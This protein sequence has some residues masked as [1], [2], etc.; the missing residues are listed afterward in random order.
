MGKSK[1]NAIGI[2]TVLLTSLIFLNACQ[3]AAP[4]VVP[5]TDSTATADT[6]DTTGSTAELAAPGQYHESP[7][8]SERV[9]RGELPPVGERLPVEPLVI[10]PVQQIGQYG[11][12]LLVGDIRATDP[13]QVRALA[14]SGLFS[15]DQTGTEVLL[16]AAKS[17][18]FSDDLKTLTIELR[19]GHRWSDGA[20]FTVD[21]ILFWWEDV[22]LNEEL[23]PAGAPAFWRP[24]GVPATFTK[25]DDTTLSI[26]FAVPYPAVMDRL[27]RTH[28]TTDPNF[29][30]PKH[31]LQQ[32]HIKYN[33]DADKLAEEAGFDTWGQHF[34]AKA[35]PSAAHMEVGKPTLWAWVPV[36][37]TMDRIVLERNPYFH[38]VDTEGN[39]LPYIDNV[40]AVLTSE[41][42]IHTLKATAGEFD[43]ETLY[44]NLKDMPV[45]R[46]GEE[47]AGYT[48][49]M[50]Q[51]LRTAML[52]L[53]PNQTYKDP[54]IRELFQNRDFRI[55]LSI[56]IDRQ[57]INNALFFD[58]GTPMQATVHPAMSFYEP[59]WGEAYIE[60]DPDRANEILDSLG[61]TE[62]DGEGFRLRPDG[63]GRISL[64]IEIGN[65]V[66]PKVEMAEMIKSTWDSLGL[67]TIVNFQAQSL[68]AQ[69]RDQIDEIMIGTWHLDRDGLFG[70]SDPQWYGY[71]NLQNV[72][73][74][75][76]VAWFTSDG[77]I[78]VEP[79]EAIKQHKEI[80]DRYLQTVPGT[81]EFD[82]FGAQ[83]YRFFAEELPMIGT[84]G[85]E[86][87]P[88][89]VSN[90][91]HN[92]PT[93][94]IWWGADNNFY[95]PYQP[96]QWYIA[97]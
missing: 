38:Q 6:P 29:M 87:W 10:Q 48:V 70:R 34:L 78:G 37:M 76:Y 23:Y 5:A 90:R 8:L 97:E 7:M 65:P 3:P 24:G 40:E 13:Q 84:V 30:M 64:I 86:P 47:A 85:L 67:E 91:L 21:D 35:S 92:V 69:R 33:P 39:Q 41:N 43:I 56:G 11:G 75:G 20:P 95:T 82:E 53:M 15:Y 16:D 59:A 45:L 25:I 9:E 83:Y 14:Q 81:P 58:L 18:E 49:Q 66:G 52:M 17:Y 55:A 4:V 26:S 42:E 46:A 44:L 50:P 36:V 61:L 19:Q 93:E 73:G 94:N 32:W 71:D 63:Q 22:Q 31:Y 88:M 74:A 1:H 62:R 28:F 89:I 68:Y 96:P 57:A 79:P 80:F 2:L 51:S 54:V 12:R 72:W 77:E 27:G 60:Y